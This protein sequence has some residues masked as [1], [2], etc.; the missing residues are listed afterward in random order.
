MPIYLYRCDCGF[1]FERLMSLD[2]PA[3]ECPQCGGQ[4]HKIP[5]GFSLGRGSSGTSTPKDKL[6]PPWQAM[7]GNPERIQRE[8]E[9]R[10]GLA[11]KHAGDALPGGPDTPS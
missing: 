10:K 3:P 6:A 11:E 7:A 4:P 2:A 1:R 9:F 5:A 8:V